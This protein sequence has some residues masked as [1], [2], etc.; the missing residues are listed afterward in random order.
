MSNINPIDLQQTD[1]QTAQTLNA[2]KGKIGM[3]PNLFATLAHAPAALNGYLSLS[4]ALEH[5][6]LTLRQRELVALAVS[7]HNACQ[8]CVSAH[9]AI[10][11]GAGMSQEE[12]N[13]ARQGKAQNA[14][15]Q[16]IVTLTQ[17]VIAQRG[18]LS[19]EEVSDARSVLGDA[20]IMEV[21]VNIALSVLTNYTNNVADTSIDFPIVSL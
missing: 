18:K 11:K 3:I 19:N 4:Q 21:I 2:V 13:Q 1:T 20:I 10:S 14:T 17:K 12:I 15:D 9:S 5:G 6:H 8:Y 16:A 7:Q